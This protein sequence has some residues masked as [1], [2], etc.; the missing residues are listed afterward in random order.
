LKI[1]ELSLVIQKKLREMFIVLV[2][3][4]AVIMKMMKRKKT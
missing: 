2:I 1:K 3:A 4:H